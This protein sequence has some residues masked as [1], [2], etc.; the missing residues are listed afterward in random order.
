VPGRARLLRGRRG[1]RQPLDFFVVAPLFGIFAGHLEHEVQGRLR[2]ALGVEL[3]VAGDPLVPDVAYRRGHGVTGRRLAPLG[4]RL[5]RL[6]EDRHGV[7][8][9]GGEGLGVLAE[10]LLVLV[11]ELLGLRVDGHRARHRGVV[12]ADDGLARDLGHVGGVHAVGT[13]ELGLDALLPGGLEE[14]RRLLVDATEV[15][16]VGVPSPDGRDDGVEVRLLLGALEP[17]DLDALLLGVGLEEIRH[18]LPVGRLVVDDVGGLRLQRAFG[19]LGADHPLDVVAAAHPIDVG[20]AAVGDGR[21]GV[22]R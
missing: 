16:E 3:H 1:D 11:G 8:G 14:R 20:V 5:D 4:S 10:L 18:A 22:G 12:H 6:E 9:L 17:D 19:E 15:D 7:V 2:V 21:V 13:H